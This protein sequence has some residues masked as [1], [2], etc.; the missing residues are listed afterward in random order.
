ME[1]NLKLA[2]WNLCLGISNKKDIVTEYLRSNDISIC[3]L[4]ETEV[5]VNYPVTILSTN[6]Y[7]LELEDSTEKMR[8]GVRIFVIMNNNHQWHS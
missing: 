1:T 3:C 2:T 7:T 6:G 4:Q 8:V 5:P